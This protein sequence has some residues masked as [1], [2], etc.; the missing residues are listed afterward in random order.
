MPGSGKFRSA[1]H[2]NIYLPQRFSEE[3]TRP[4]MQTSVESRYATHRTGY[5][6]GMTAPVSASNPPDLLI[7]D[8]M[9]ALSYQIFLSDPAS[10]TSEGVYFC[11]LK[12]YGSANGR[13]DPP[14]KLPAGF[15]TYRDAPGISGSSALAST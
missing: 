7:R 9:K 2:P 12:P 6:D 8:R 1:T 5:L 10:A 3:T 13:Y 15:T 11:G 4:L 14:E